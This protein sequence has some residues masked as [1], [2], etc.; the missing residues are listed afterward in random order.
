MPYT[1]D[2]LPEHIKQM[3]MHAQKVF[4][5]SFNSAMES[6]SG[7]SAEKEACAHKIAYSAVHKAGYSKDEASGKWMMMQNSAIQEFSMSI[8]RTSYDKPTGRMGFRMTA[9]DTKLD[10]YKTQMSRSLFESFVRH[11]K[12]NDPLPQEFSMFRED[13]W[14]GGMPYVSIAHYK[15]AGG[16]N[17]PGKFDNIYLDGDQLKGTGELFDNS[18]GRSVFRSLS[19]DLEGKAEFSDKIRASIGFLDYK[20]SHG[21][22]IFERKS[23]A[24]ECPQCASGADN[25]VFLDGQLVH[26]AF[27]RKPVNPRTESEVEYSM[28]DEIMT[29]RDDAES[30][31]GDAVE[32]LSLEER[33]SVSLEIRSNTDEMD[34]G[35]FDFISRAVKYANKSAPKGKPESKTQYA[36]PENYKYSIDEGHIRAAVA[37]FNHP[38]QQE[39]GGYSDGQWSAIG[40]KIAAAATRLLGFKHSYSNGKISTAEEKKSMS[41]ENTTTLESSGNVVPTPLE[42]AVS[43][44]MSSVTQARSMADKEAALVSIQPALDLLGKTIQD[45][46][47]IPTPAPSSEI[48]SVLQS[49][50]QISQAVQQMAERMDGLTG[51]VAVLKAS[52]VNSQPA[53]IARSAVPTPRSVQVSPHSAAQIQASQ[54]SADSDK[55]VSQI[56]RLAFT[57]VQPRM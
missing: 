46:F 16:K 23:A 17:V 27:T 47:V 30:I 13:G 35:T 18:L 25:K 3:P 4:M 51:D 45:E 52:N 19:K 15:S 2:T 37:Y 28:N 34:D 44:L 10:L 54:I 22:F 42:V 40:H 29:K 32:E 8:I 48:A 12:N 14:D 5:E 21:D 11:I 33:S 1:M 49:L 36:D 43:G 9:S 57:S 20:H 56:D 6:C 50:T 53:K 24:D 38:G 7:T 55:K 41:N 39:K 26:I 31:V